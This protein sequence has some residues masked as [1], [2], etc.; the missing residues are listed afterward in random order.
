VARTPSV[1]SFSLIPNYL[2]IY[3]VCHEVKDP[4]EVSFS[5]YTL[6]YRIKTKA[7][8]FFKKKFWISAYF[9]ER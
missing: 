6:K 5:S 3:L 9:P 7:D 8:R 4:C 2:E 1:S